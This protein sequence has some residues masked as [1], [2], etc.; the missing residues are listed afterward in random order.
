MTGRDLLYYS[1]PI[2]AQSSLSRKILTNKKKA[3]ILSWKLSAPYMPGWCWSRLRFQRKGS[4]GELNISGQ[5]KM[6]L[7]IMHKVDPEEW[8]KGEDIK[9]DREKW[10]IP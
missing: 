3:K 8:S 1:R 9:D 7:N 2:I 6:P 10:D 4:R 5:G